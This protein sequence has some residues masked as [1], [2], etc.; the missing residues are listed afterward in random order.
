LILKEGIKK[1]LADSIEAA[2]KVG[3]GTVKVVQEGGKE[4]LFSEHQACVHCG[5][6]FPPIEPRLFSFNSPY[7][8]C[9][10]CDGLGNCQEIDPDLVVPDKTKSI[11]EGAIVAWKRGGKSMI[12]YLRRVLRNLASELGFSMDTAFKDLKKEHKE[13]ILYGERAR[14]VGAHSKASSRTWNAASKKPNPST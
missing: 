11:G 8:A 12:I 1:R 4:T 3:K 9:P 14:T 13:V 10:G 2:L 7:G 5:L 6:S